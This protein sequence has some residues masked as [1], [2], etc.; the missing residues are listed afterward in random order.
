MY[1]KNNFIMAGKFKKWPP[2]PDVK[3]PESTKNLPA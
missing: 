2:I 3:S 1:L